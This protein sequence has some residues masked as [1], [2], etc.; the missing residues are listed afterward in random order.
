MTI[1]NEFWI[2]LFTTLVSFA[3]AYFAYWLV[4]KPRLVAYSPNSTGFVLDPATEGSQPIY[5]RAG[6][7]IVQ[8]AGRLSANN[9]Q[10]VAEVGMKPWGYNLVPN[11]DHSIREGQRGEWIVEIP[12]LGPGETI[13]L[14]ILNG[15]NI[16]TVRAREGAAKVVD[17]HYQRVLPSWF[18]FGV[19]TLVL[20]GAVTV[21]YLVYGI[22]YTLVS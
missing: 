21:I 15:P 10:L 13:T 5:V 16:S 4:G 2:V 1:P 12:F 20:I 14:Q 7:V 19:L 17:V 8:N 22:F 6:Q 9:I 3:V 18:N 11:V